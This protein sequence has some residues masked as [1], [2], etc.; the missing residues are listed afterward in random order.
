MS[1]LRTQPNFQTELWVGMPNEGKTINTKNFDFFLAA[2]MRSFD[3]TSRIDDY[4]LCDQGS[5]SMPK[6]IRIFELKPKMALALLASGKLD[7]AVIGREMMKEFNYA[8]QPGQL[9]AQELLDLKLGRCVLS[10][11]I[12]DNDNAKTIDDLNGRRVVTKYPEILKSWC[13]ATGINLTIISGINNDA[14][15][16]GGIEGYPIFDPSVTVIADMVQSG[17]SLVMNGWRPLGIKDTGWNPVRD[18][19]LDEKNYGKKPNYVDFSSKFLDNLPATI[20][21][22]NAVLVGTTKPLSK[23]KQEIKAE[24]TA[25]FEK[26]TK[27]LSSNDVNPTQGY[28]ASGDR[29]SWQN[30]RQPQRRVA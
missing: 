25:R 28:W 24:L 11:A 30:L 27:S 18:A 21:R 13:R 16:C 1:R 7:C 10:F 12:R 29:P 5:M 4:S 23:G 20:M 8:A 2:G 9:Q 22:S 3:K 14:D 26:A 15:L 19:Y 17:E 6:N